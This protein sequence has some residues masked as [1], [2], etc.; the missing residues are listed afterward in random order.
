[1]KEIHHFLQGFLRLILTGHILKCDACLFLHI[2]LGIALANAHHASAFGHLPHQPYEH[3]S[4]QTDRKD[5]GQ[6]QFKKCLAHCIGRLASELHSGFLEFIH[7]SVVIDIS[8]IIIRI[9]LAFFF[10]TAA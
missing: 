10:R 2:H 6:E 8:C 4:H 5:H 7:Q 3:K 1:M 9:S